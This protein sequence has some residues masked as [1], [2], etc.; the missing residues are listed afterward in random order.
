MLQKIYIFSSLERI[1][2]C[3]GLYIIF[4]LSKM[5]Y[6]RTFSKKAYEFKFKAWKGQLTSLENFDST[7]V[8]G[9]SLPW[10]K[11]PCEKN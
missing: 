5:H 7:Y 4:Y 9:E 6:N 10:L 1:L 2:V 3:E 8:I 11:K